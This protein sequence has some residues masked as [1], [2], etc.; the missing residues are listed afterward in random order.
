[1]RKCA[2]DGEAARMIKIA[3]ARAEISMAELARRLDTTPQAFHKRARTGHFS[4]SEW[5]AIA[6]ALGGW[7]FVISLTPPEPKE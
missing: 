6:A 5:R 3:C 2:E 7:D 1:M 4:L